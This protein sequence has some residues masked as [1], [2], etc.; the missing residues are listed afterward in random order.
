MEPELWPTAILNRLFG[1]PVS[2]FLR[3]IGVPPENPAHPIPNYLA[4]EILVVVFMMVLLAW[5]RAR[6]SA[7][8]PGKLQQLLE[9]LANGLGSQT[10]EIVGHGGLAFLP[11]LFTI[12]VFILLCNILGEI[13]HLGTPTQ[14]VYVTVGCSLAALVYYHYHGVRHHGVFGYL[15]T[16]GG[17]I[18]A[19]AWLMFPIEIVSHL[20]RG[21]S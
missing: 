4:L 1:G 8:R 2:A 5:V 9:M 13:P 21:L 18:L 19:I 6:L 7:D 3:A 14:S 17:P 10:E 12:F 11:F 20:A 15:R 16:F